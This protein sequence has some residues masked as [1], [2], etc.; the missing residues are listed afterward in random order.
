MP[1]NDNNR[2]TNN[3]VLNMSLA[4]FCR[5]AIDLLRNN[6]DEKFVRFVLGGIDDGRQVVIDPILNTV[7]EHDQLRVR[8]DY[9]SLLGIDKNIRVRSSMIVYP[10]AKRENTLSA[11]LHLTYTFTCSRVCTLLSNNIL[12]HLRLFQGSVYSPGTQDT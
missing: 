7:G 1:D 10:V 2:A 9:D 5:R 11:N 4:G 12:S 8:R 6:N 3:N